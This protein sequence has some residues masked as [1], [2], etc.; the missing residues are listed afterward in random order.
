MTGSHSD[1]E[2]YMTAA[3]FE[4]D[5]RTDI[6]QAR[7]YYEQGRKEHSHYKKLYLDEVGMEI[8]H[9]EG[10]ANNYDLCIEKYRA[11][12]NHFKGD[13]TFH[14]QVLNSSLIHR[15][16]HRIHSLIVWYAMRFKISDIFIYNCVI[17]PSCFF[18][19]DMVET[20][21]HNELLWHNLAQLQ[22]RGYSYNPQTQ[23]LSFSKEFMAVQ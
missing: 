22:L 10:G 12:I 17:F 13:I 15:S 19:S 3:R 16:V 1:P 18:Y 23:R 11:A 6:E 4:F 2:I 5:E 21:K 20:Y 14:M 8:Q 9:H 7:K